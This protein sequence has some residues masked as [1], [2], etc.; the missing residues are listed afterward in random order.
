MRVS[1]STHQLFLSLQSLRFII[2]TGLPFWWNWSTCW[3]LLQFFYFKWPY[4]EGQLSYSDPDCDSHSPALTD[5]F[6]S[7]KASICST[8]AFP[9][10]VN[11]D[12]TVVSVSTDFLSNSQLDAPFHRIAYDYSCADWGGLHDHLRDIPWEDIFK[13]DASAAASEFCEWVQVGSDVHISHIKYQVF[14]PH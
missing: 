8:M 10:L 4:P 11:S 1:Q 12:H 13:L 9:P 7:S 2:R 6:I 14:K 5:L 3:T